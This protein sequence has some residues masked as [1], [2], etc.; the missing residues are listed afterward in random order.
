MD[1][2]VCRI[3]G[4]TVALYELR[5]PSS[6]SGCTR[7]EG[8]LPCAR[9]GH[10]RPGH[11]GVFSGAKRHGCDYVV[12]ATDSLAESRCGCD[13]YLRATRPLSEATFATEDVLLVDTVIPRLRVVDPPD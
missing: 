2:V 10:P 1:D 6:G 5:P 8:S 7:C 3:C 13:G 9:C 12:R 4:T 11:F